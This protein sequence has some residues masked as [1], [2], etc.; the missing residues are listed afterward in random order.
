LN[1]NKIISVIIPYFK[2]KLFFRKTFNSITHQKFKNF[3]IIIIYDDE[4]KTDLDHIKSI[5]KNKKNIKLIINHKNLGAG[6][7][8]NKGIKIAKGKYL[9]FIDADDL[10]KK[11]KLNRQYNFM[12]KKNIKISHTSYNIINSKDKI[13][14]TRPAKKTQNYND[15]ISSCDVGLSSVM[16]KKEIL[17]KHKFPNLITKE[18]YSLW[19]K[20]SKKYSIYGI[21]SNLVQWRKTEKSLSSNNVQKLKDA[22]TIYYHQENYGFIN[23]I[24]KVLVLSMNFLKKNIKT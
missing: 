17:K 24:I 16:V 1:K 21:N 14:G 18:D 3:E 7:S 22:F 20:L 13:I 11:E 15:L 6:L 12:K 23:S 4:D 8:R 9:A 2:K 5:I 19:L 10:W